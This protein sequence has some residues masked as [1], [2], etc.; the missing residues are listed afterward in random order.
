MKV[1]VILVFFLCCIS[2]VSSAQNGLEMLMEKGKNYLL[3][4]ENEQAEEVLQKALI[5]SV[6]AKDLKSTAIIYNNLGVAARRLGNDKEGIESYEL[7]LEVY[8]KI[9]DDT[10][11][12][13][14]QYNL[15]VAL[16][17]LGSYELAIRNFSSA[18]VLFEKI[19]DEEKT[20]KVYDVLGNIYNDIKNHKESIQYHRSA[21]KIYERILDTVGTSRAALNLG[22]AYIELGEFRKAR[23]YLFRA[24]RIKKELNI[25]TAACD[26]QIGDFF[27]EIKKL[28]SAEI[29]YKQSLNT[30]KKEGHKTNLATAYWHMGDLLIEQGEYQDAIPFLNKAFQIADSL[31]L[32]QLLILV[33]G[34]QIEVGKITGDQLNEKYEQLILLNEGVLG[35]AS[36]KEISRFEV[37]YGVLKK[38]QEIELKNNQ[39]IIKEIENDKLS[40]RNMFLVFGVL[41]AA[42]FI[43]MV[44]YF[45]LKLRKGK[46]ETEEKNELL[47]SSYELVD[48]L[49]TEL[50]HRTKKYFQMFGGMLKYDQ[51]RTTNDDVSDLL[52]KY[53]SRVEAMSQIQRYLLKEK[54]AS[55]DVQLNLYLEELLANI[56]LVLNN[57]DPKVK[58]TSEFASVSC[59]YDKALR[60]GLVMNEMVSNSFEH[61]FNSIDLPSLDLKLEETAQQEV[62]LLIRDNGVGLRNLQIADDSIGISLMKMIL[63]SVDGDLTYEKEKNMGTSVIITC[64]HIQ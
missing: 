42:V 39:L 17:R 31:G 47:T 50:S 26:A 52:E 10:L 29:Y 48:N 37:K 24:K 55:K 5:Q 46:K 45:Y 54:T 19:R 16:K 23:L 64:P 6:E 41:I 4:S 25:S 28:D 36:L 27:M 43:F 2:S 11:I 3:A 49:H 58:I 8:K 15:G 32:N 56:N 1:K 61:G 51:D 22:G 44:I 63:N 33:I 18:V 30:R 12:A 62:V 34:S 57:R 9:G 59:D 53:S 35:E 21:M 14:S 40:L 60:I 7:A 13:G 38:D 20:A